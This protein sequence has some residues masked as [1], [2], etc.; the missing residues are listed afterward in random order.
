MNRIT[1]AALFSL[2]AALLLGGCGSSNKEGQLQGADSSPLFGN[3]PVV[4]D[5]GCNQCHSAVTEALTGEG[6]ITQYQL[7]SPHNQPGLGC[8]SCHGGALGHPDPLNNPP[9]PLAGQTPAQ[10]AARCATCH[11]GVQ[12]LSVNGVAT[13]APAS[14]VTD[15]PAS[16]HANMRLFTNGLCIRCHTHE[17]AVLSN[18]SGFT[19]GDNV[20][21]NTAF[22]PPLFT[23]VF[24][25]IK[26][27]TCHQHGGGLR[28]VQTKLDPTNP[29]SPNV[30]WD[31]N[32]NARVDQFDLCTS[33]HTLNNN[34]NGNLIVD[35]VALTAGGGNV[36]TDRIVDRHD[37]EWFRILASTH[38]DNPNTAG[39]IEGYNLRK[40]AS[41]TCYD[42]HGHEAMTET[43]PTSAT[44]TIH[45]DWAESAHAGHLLTAKYTAT[46]DATG[47]PLANNAATVALAMNAGVDGTSWDNR[48]WDGGSTS[49]HM[50]HTSTGNANYLTDQRID[51]ATG[52]ATGY[53]P[54]NNDFSH[55][56]T[57]Q[58]ELLYCW[59][60]HS[61]AGTGSLRNTTQAILSFTFNNLPIVITGKGKS[62]ACIVCHGGRGSATE[63]T[64]IDDR[65]SR[66]NG[67][68]APTAGV[69][70]NDQTHL[71]FE[72]AGQN[73]A[74]PAT[75]VHDDIGGGVNGSG[76]CA[77]CHM[78]SESHGKS[79]T[80]DALELDAAD[81]PIAIRNQALCNTCHATGGLTSPI[82][83]AG[84]IDL[85]AGYAEASTI[86][87]NF[88]NN[89]AGFTNYLNV[90]I[91]SGNY[92]AVD[93]TGAF[94]IP[95]EAYGAFQNAKLNG[96]EPCAYL[97][98][99][100]YARRLL[101]D[102]IDW[103]DN[104]VLDGAI[105][106]DAVAFPLAAAWFN[107]PTGTATRP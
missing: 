101:F 30:R 53:D 23:G 9:F 37:T 12:T 54:A 91:N 51:P 79:H 45:K 78:P 17:G 81:V 11:D 65:S 16:N 66:F 87:N 61:N 40:A 106:F 94:I 10:K 41:T 22:G 36:P 13:V 46:S 89:V 95:N 70:F 4:G 102:S 49:C 63:A 7:S 44:L 31:P 103:M 80:F 105:T 55:L 33:C 99:S 72:Y 104:G 34:E 92:N 96:D 90:A 35:G 82:T 57:G 14:N 71:A 32:A 38:Y 47:T 50:C 83:V 58:N 97:H 68:H 64:I 8:E 52:Q 77:S 3:V 62:S 39:V 69:M 56:A 93:G 86:L 73:Y 60:C 15:F 76:P 98:N 84:L 28:V 19:G 59:G 25:G 75:F 107:A 27:E 88:V 85:K 26:C 100:L 48:D 5:T 18:V 67:H 21:S 42:C 29:A 2:L 6:L 24:T 1:M 74:S 20:L 43:N